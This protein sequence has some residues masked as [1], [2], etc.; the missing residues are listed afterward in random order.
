MEDANQHTNVLTKEL[1]GNSEKHTDVLSKEK[2]SEEFLSLETDLGLQRE[3]LVTESAS[4]AI[5]SCD[6][7]TDSLIVFTGD[8]KD[9]PSF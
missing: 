2:D 7:D 6:F 5:G 3:N 8:A 1:G 9:N 4:E